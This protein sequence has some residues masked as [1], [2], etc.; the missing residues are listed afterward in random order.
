MAILKYNN[1]DKWISL[2]IESIKNRLKKNNNLSDLE[3]IDEARKNLEIIGDN[4]HTHYHDDRYLPKIEQETSE[5]IQ[6]DNNLKELIISEIKKLCDIINNTIDSISQTI[7]NYIDEIIQK[8]RYD[9]EKAIKEEA[10]IRRQEDLKLHNSILATSNIYLK[11]D[12]VDNKANKVPRYSSE[13]H[14]VLPSGIEI[15]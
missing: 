12:D 2:Y 8:E 4:N 9:R 14:L 13:G 15:W 7:S 1:G 6:S 3:N 10:D 5:R 11:L